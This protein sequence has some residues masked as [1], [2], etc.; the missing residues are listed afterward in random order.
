MTARQPV[1]VLACGYSGAA[2]IQRLLKIFARVSLALI[3][4]AA[5]CMAAGRYA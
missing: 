2:R 4:V 1:V 3:A 5:I